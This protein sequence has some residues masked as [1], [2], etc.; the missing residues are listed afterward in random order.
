M[1]S[2]AREVLITE[3][4]HGRNVDAEDLVFDDQA[5]SEVLTA[6]YI[7]SDRARNQAAGI[8]DTP[9]SYLELLFLGGAMKKGW[10]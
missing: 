5:L 1:H 9:L 4:K 7:V 10:D 3:R 8:R 2:R 6:I